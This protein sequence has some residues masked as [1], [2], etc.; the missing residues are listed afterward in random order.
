MSRRLLTLLVFG[1]VSWTTP[2]CTAFVLGATGHLEHFEVS[3]H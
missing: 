3:L 2:D 1:V